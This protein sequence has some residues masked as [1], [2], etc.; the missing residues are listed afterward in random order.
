MACTHTADCPLFP[1][2]SASLGAWRT[3]YCDTE[4]QWRSCAR[5]ERSMRGEP[6]PLALLPNGKIVGLL[7]K[8]EEHAADAAAQVQAQASAVATATLE[9]HD[10]LPTAVKPSLWHRLFGRHK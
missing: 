10:D 9:H 7:A 5:Y 1:K 3:H 6:V 8:D 4:H 2:L